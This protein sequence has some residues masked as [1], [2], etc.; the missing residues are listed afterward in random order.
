[1]YRGQRVFFKASKDTIQ[2]LLECN[3]LSATVW[4]DCLDD[5]KKYYLQHKKW[6]GK[7]ELQALLKGKYRLHSQSIQAVAHKYLFARENAHKAIQKGIKT[8]KYPYR[9]KKYF[10][11]KWVDKAFTISENGKITLSLGVHGRKRV[12]PLVVYAQNLPKGTIKEIELCYDHGLYLS[13]SYDDGQEPLP[14]T[15]QRS[16]GVDLGEIHTLASFCENG[17]S[18]LLSGRKIRSLHRLRNQ[19]LKELQKRMSRCQKGSRKW[20]KYQRA[21][22]YLLSKSERQLRDA[23]HKTTK[24][25]VD[26]CLEQGVSDVYVGDPEGV[27]RH[28]KKK[29][30]KTVNQKLSNWSFGTVK[31]YIVYK[32]QSKGI[33]VQFVNEAYSSQTCPV[34]K[35]KKKVRTRNYRCHC[36]YESHRD[37][38]GAKNLLSQALYGSFEPWGKEKTPKYL[39]LA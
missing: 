4:N 22:R 25:F 7:T 12:P 3:R 21:K 16:A 29:R 19:K 2:Q 23:L 17:E 35:R 24:A 20:K 6:I 36:G 5:A 30:R 38:H 15:P 27:Q 10:P 11:T 39:R 34:C 37:I 1:M 8:A 9:K 32:C 13:V 28:T 14:Y 26:W 31:Q 18:L 33:Q